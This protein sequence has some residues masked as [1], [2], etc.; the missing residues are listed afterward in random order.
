MH[1]VDLSCPYVTNDWQRGVTRAEVELAQ[2]HGSDPGFLSTDQSA[3]TDDPTLRGA[4]RPNP[5]L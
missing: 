4:T 3:D 5:I 1:T 2:D